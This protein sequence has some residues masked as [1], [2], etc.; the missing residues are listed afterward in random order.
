[1]NNK[2]ERTVTRKRSQP[3]TSPIKRLYS[4]V[5]IIE[6]EK[7]KK[8]TVPVHWVDELKNV[9]Y[10]PPKDKK[11][12]NYYISNWVSPDKGW[13]ENI[14]LKIN[15]DKG[16]KEIGDVC[17]KFDSE[18]SNSDFQETECNSATYSNRFHIR[19]K[20][21]DIT[22]EKVAESSLFSSRLFIKSP[23]KHPKIVS[24]QKYQE[25]NVLN[26]EED[27]D[28]SNF[29]QSNTVQSSLSSV[30]QHDSFLEPVQKTIPRGIGGTFFYDKPPASFKP[31]DERRFQYAIFVELASIKS[32][33]Q[34]SL[35]AVEKLGR[36]TEPEDSLFY[37]YKSNDI[38]E[39]DEIE[40]FLDNK[41]KFHLLV[42][43]LKQIGGSSISA[44]V[45]KVLDKTMSKNVQSLFNKA[46]RHG[47]KSFRKTLLYKAI[48]GNF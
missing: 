9:V 8:M 3:N 36:R 5:T 10:W 30:C 14:Y 32:E 44:S 17:M 47:K 13:R 33:I 37:I 18:S 25:E 46:G 28:F 11:Q 1:M 23:S 29:Y 22:V 38:R 42:R 43:Q 34:K 4:V 19:E 7:Q 16:T 48:I 6:D 20:S 45:N 12:I 15:L 24:T 21:P 27:L 26:L 35:C 41:E 31:M 39:F 40:I 2:E